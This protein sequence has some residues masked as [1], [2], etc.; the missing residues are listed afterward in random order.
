MA[1]H[2]RQVLTEL[3]ATSHAA[4]QFVKLQEERS[5]R[6]DVVD[7]DL[8]TYVTLV[9]VHQMELRTTSHVVGKFVM[10][11]EER[12]VKMEFVNEDLIVTYVTLVDVC[13]LEPLATNLA[14]EWDAK[15][16]KGLDAKMEDV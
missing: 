14:L 15:S 12:S 7:E 9:E 6:M 1:G 5:V 4:V 16:P 2:V 11:K 13:Q 3:P 10:P 8:V